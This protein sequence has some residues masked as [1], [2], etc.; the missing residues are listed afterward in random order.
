MLATLKKLKGARLRMPAALRV[1]TKAMG[2]GTTLPG[3][4]KEA[5]DGRADQVLPGEIDFS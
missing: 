4:G 5:V 1:D 3:A 2:R